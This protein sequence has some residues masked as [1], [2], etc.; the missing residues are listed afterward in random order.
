MEDQDVTGEEKCPPSAFLGENLSRHLN[1]SHHHSRHEGQV[2]LHS[3]RYTAHQNL[4]QILS[5]MK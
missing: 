2:N 3:N 5:F 1:V 4:S